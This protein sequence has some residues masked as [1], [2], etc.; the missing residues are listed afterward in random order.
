VTVVLLRV[1]VVV[2]LGAV[3][4]VVLVVLGAVVVVVED[5]VAPDPEQA[6]PL[7]RKSR[8]APLAPFHE[9]MNPNETDPPDPNEE[10]HDAPDTDGVAPVR[11]PPPHP[12]GTDC[13]SGKVNVNVQADTASPVLRSV[14][15]P[16]NPPG[17]WLI[18]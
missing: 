13:P 5:D 16:W 1:V 6:T 14:T 7:N 17:H 8:A 4:V 11:H 2:V 10:F 12:W 18:T 15:D 9:P 3:V